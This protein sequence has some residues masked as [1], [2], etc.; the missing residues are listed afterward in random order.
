[1]NVTPP[2]DPPLAR[3]ESITIIDGSSSTRPASVRAWR[4]SSASTIAHVPL[5]DHRRNCDRTLVHAPVLRGQEPPLAPRVSDVQH[6]VHHQAQV[7][8]VARPTL[9]WP[10]Q[11]RFEQ[12]PLV[13][14]RVTR[15]RPTSASAGGAADWAPNRT[16]PLRAEPGDA[17]LVLACWTWTPH[18]Q[19][20][21]VRRAGRHWRSAPSV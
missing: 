20:C 14:G 2:R 17:S 16:H 11:L 15:V 18:W 5:C 19:R 1:W 3:C 9:A 6:R 4:W 8:A 21:G 10:T 12:S 7:R 13:V